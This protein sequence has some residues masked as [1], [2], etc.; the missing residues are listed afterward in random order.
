MRSLSTA[1]HFT[2]GRHTADQ[3]AA[4]PADAVE[5]YLKVSVCVDYNAQN[6]V[7]PNSP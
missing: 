7:A 2:T 5:T 6:I 4:K 3:L 1:Y